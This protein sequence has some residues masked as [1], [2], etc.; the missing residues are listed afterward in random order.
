MQAA[1]RRVSLDEFKRN[2]LGI[3]KVNSAFC[4]LRSIFLLFNQIAIV[5]DI[6]NFTLK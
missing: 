3:L 2:I 6:N 5:N 1:F 4:I